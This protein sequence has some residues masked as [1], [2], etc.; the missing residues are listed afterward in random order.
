M[1]K[2]ERE[3]LQ[4]AADETNI[5][6]AELRKVDD[7]LCD[8]DERQ[9]FEHFG[10]AQSRNTSALKIINSLLRDSEKE[11]EDPKEAKPAAK[12]V[13]NRKPKKDEE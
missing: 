1:R 4:K 13:K 8:G 3:Q 12:E 11:E 10:V 6:R 5:A 2:A 9:A 7:C